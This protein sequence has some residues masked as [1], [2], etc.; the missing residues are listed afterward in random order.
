MMTLILKVNYHVAKLLANKYLTV[1]DIEP[2]DRKVKLQIDNSNAPPGKKRKV[3][4]VTYKA[5][6]RASIGRYSAQQ[7]SRYFIKKLKFDYN[8]IISAHF[9]GA[10]ERA[11][12]ICY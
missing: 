2:A 4:Y 10:L 1:R 8:G 6:E 5:E 11:L 12:I 3:P 7:L 9:K